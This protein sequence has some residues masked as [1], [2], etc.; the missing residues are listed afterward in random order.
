MSGF[1][2]LNLFDTL[3][4]CCSDSAA[5]AVDTVLA[6]VYVVSNADWRHAG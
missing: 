3:D 6:L 4:S 2:T 5:A 1:A